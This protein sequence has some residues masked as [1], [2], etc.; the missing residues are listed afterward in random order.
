MNTQD[1]PFAEDMPYWKTSKSGVESWMDKTEVLIDSIGGRV[2]TR[3]IGKSGGKEGIMFGF[4]ING[5]AYKLMWPVLPTKK[6]ADRGAALR[7]CATMIYHDTK[8]RINRI[9][10]FGPRVVFSDWLVLES[11][12]T[13]AETAG[14]MVPAAIQG[15]KLLK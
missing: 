14:D 1:L 7:Q 5:D 9:R 15:I 11:G 4:F 3:I 8:A 6:E 2:D 12:K 10:I 13:L